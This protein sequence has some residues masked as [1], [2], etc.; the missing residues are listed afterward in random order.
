MVSRES[1]CGRGRRAQDR[2]LPPPPP[3]LLTLRAP[4]RIGKSAVGGERR[5]GNLNEPLSNSFGC[6]YSRNLS[7]LARWPPTTGLFATSS[8]PLGI[9]EEIRCEPLPPLSAVFSATRPCVYRYP[10]IPIFSELGEKFESFKNQIFSAASLP[11]DGFTGATNWPVLE[12]KII[13][14]FDTLSSGYLI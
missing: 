10:S 12:A 9:V 11:V 4:P 13:S 2:L 6:L 14:C 3:P 5:Y 7:S 1:S 8:A